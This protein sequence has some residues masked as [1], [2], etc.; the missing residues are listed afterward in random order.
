MKNACIEQNKNLIRPVSKKTFSLNKKRE[1]PK[2]STEWRSK[3]SVGG[4]GRV[5]KDGKH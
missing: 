4:E 5:E 3:L 1:S 2:K